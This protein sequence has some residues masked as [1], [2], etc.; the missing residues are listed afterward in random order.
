MSVLNDGAQAFQTYLKAALPLLELLEK[1]VDALLEL[2]TAIQGSSKEGFKVIESI[3]DQSGALH[4]FLI[5]E[6][7]QD[8]DPRLGVDPQ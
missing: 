1:E 4:V 8:Q 5:I 2:M 3:V 6:Q 7:I